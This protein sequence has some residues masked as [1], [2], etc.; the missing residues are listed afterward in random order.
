VN[1]AS[2]FSVTPN[3]FEEKALAVFAYQ[4]AHVPFYQT[5]CKLMHKQPENVRTINDIPFLPIEFFK[6][7]QIIAEGKQAQAIFE[8]ST[9]TGTTPSKHFVADLSYL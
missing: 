1:I 2:I 5:Y 8:S 4:F 7:Q 9:T 6:T 3:N